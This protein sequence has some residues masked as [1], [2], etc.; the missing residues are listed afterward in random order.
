MDESAPLRRNSSL[1]TARKQ[2]NIARLILWLGPVAALLAVTL[3]HIDGGDWQRGDSGFYA[4]V[5]TQA[6]ESGN[7]WTLHAGS[8]ADTGTEYFNKPPLTFWITGLACHLFGANAVIVRATTVFAACAVVLLTGLI[9]ITLSTRSIAAGAM[10][11]TA[12][13][14]EFFRRTHELSLDMWQLVWL[15]CAMYCAA[16]SA[17]RCSAR[18]LVVMGLPIGCALMT[19]PLL[20]LLAIVL[21]GVWILTLRTDGEFPSRSRERGLLGALGVA[22]VVALPWHLSMMVIHGDTFTNQYFGAEMASRAMGEMTEGAGSTTTSMFYVKHLV[23]GA[24]PW[25]VLA[26][27]GIGI[28]FVRMLGRTGVSTNASRLARLW[29]IW[30]VGWFV[31]L[32]LFPDRRDRYALVLHPAIGTLAGVFLAS[33]RVPHL[34]KLLRATRNWLGPIAVGVGVVV[35]FLP[36]RA[37]KP[38]NDQWPALFA[39]LREHHEHALEQKQQW[40][41]DSI[42][43]GAWEAQRGSRMYHEFG[44]WP[45]QTRD[46]AGKIVHMPG[47]GDL[48]L[49]HIR[50]GWKPGS[51]E[52]VVF[53]SGDVTVTTLDALPWEPV[54][55][56][57]PGESNDN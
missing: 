3:Q 21:I 12:L 46:R 11:A 40:R 22:L 32:T 35:A 25:V 55:S 42:C 19:K 29:M 56:V 41:F 13:N 1:S 33:I 23:E 36:I 16:R 20:G 45:R 38:V 34:A 7:L 30:F 9:A 28:W 47:V 52:T 8:P 43:A 57:D 10:I 17:K 15:M 31:L 26:I 51:T 50:D 18:W 37:H 5:G 2:N 49:Y 6:W 54:E 44:A 4:A 39:F 27:L 53:S 48:V 24:Q 14:L